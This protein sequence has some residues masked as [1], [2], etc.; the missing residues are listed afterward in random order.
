MRG[1]LVLV[2]PRLDEF[3]PIPGSAVCRLDCPFTLDGVRASSALSHVLHWP[4]SRISVLLRWHVA[5]FFAGVTK[6]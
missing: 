1:R 5:Y 3:L 2:P 4:C 6:F